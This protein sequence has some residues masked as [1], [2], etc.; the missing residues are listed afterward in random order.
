M[1]KKFIKQL[2]EWR[3][4]L[5][6]YPESAFE[7]NKTSDFIAE[8]LIE[9]GL[10]V[11]RNIGGT[12]IVA[13]LKIGDGK[14]IIGLR[15]DIDAI[16][17]QEIGL[18]PYASK[19]PGKMHAC[20]HDGHITTMLGVAKVLTERKNFSGI[21]RFIFQ[22]A[23]EPGKGSQRMI[24]DGL[25]DRFPVDEI[26]AF[27][28][29]PFI[30]EGHVHT[31]VGGIMASEDNFAIRIKGKGS[32]ASSPHLGIDPLVTAAQIIIGLQT[33]V[34]RSSNP[35]DPSVVSCTEIHTDGIHNAI[36][37][38]VEIL[39]DT[40]SCSVE[41]QELIETRMRTIC[42]GI[43]EMNGAGFEVDYTHE[44]FPT[45]N[46]EKC[47]NTIGKAAKN[48][49]GEKKVNLNCETWMASEDF[50]RFL[51]YIPGCLVL[52]GSGKSDIPLENIPLHNSMYDY[53]DEILEIGVEIFAEL[54]KTRL[55]AK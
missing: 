49:V 52:I 45:I 16:N 25:F 26:Y 22:P 20:G 8:K 15:A 36:P 40:R 13:T 37:S 50:G 43:C 32:H 3:H 9:M 4:E 11:H 18:I 38:N 33:I 47:V 48:I 29:A 54:I 34:S 17:M 31:R 27:H 41:M 7:E 53:N 19:I 55:L 35:L 30:Q 51:N 24:D 5:H 21:V 6:M 2:K 44:F 23:E 14:E 42:K 46:W 1:E 28:N 39:G 10:E 12:G